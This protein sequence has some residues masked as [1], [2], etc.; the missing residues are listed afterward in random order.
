MIAVAFVRNGTDIALLDV[1]DLTREMAI[2]SCHLANE[3]ELD[4]AV[5]AVQVQGVRALKFKAVES[6]DERQWC[7]VVDVSLGYNAICTA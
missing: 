2:S 3:N 4:E 7:E 6:V 5:A 1:A